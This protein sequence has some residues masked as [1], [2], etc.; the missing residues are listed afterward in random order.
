ML[1][2]SKNV[3]I[4][5]YLNVSM[6]PF[7]YA[8]KT[9]STHILANHYNI[10]LN[11]IE[12]GA[13]ISELVARLKIWMRDNSYGL[14]LCEN[15]W[16]GMINLNIPAG[17]DVYYLV[18][19]NG[20]DGRLYSRDHVSYLSK[21]YKY[22]ILDESYGD[23]ADQSMIQHRPDNVIVLKSLSKTLASPGTR[24][25]WA[26]ANTDV[27]QSLTHYKGRHIIAGAIEQILPNLLAQV[28]E[29][30][31]RMMET[32]EY[33]HDHYDCIEVYGNF[34]MLKHNYFAKVFKSS[35]YNDLYRLSLINLETFKQYEKELNA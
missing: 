17:N 5:K 13:G 18:N 9:L 15:A 19:P 28:P 6:N 34:V 24:F 22:V 4:D 29:H 1:D 33:I 35:V 16:P 31:N 12:I 25:G 20:L 21:I 30:I 11:T 26:I 27:I 7:E 8:H 2:L 32:K 10:E 14:T 3:C 23:F